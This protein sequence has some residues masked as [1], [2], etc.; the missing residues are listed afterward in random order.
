MQYSSIVPIAAKNIKY[1]K[2]EA[3]T[4]YDI[5]S[6][7]KI[8][9]EIRKKYQIIDTERVYIRTLGIKERLLKEQKN[10]CPYCKNIIKPTDKT[11]I[12]HWQSID[13][14]GSN[15][16]SNLCVMHEQCNLEKSNKVIV[17]E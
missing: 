10:K 8:G 1:F 14:F 15:E 17:N 9:I 11:H 6:I 2:I 13:E 7:I 5:N 4:R 16:E 12:D 3:L